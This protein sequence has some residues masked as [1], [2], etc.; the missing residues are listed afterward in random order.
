MHNYQLTITSELIFATLLSHVFTFKMFVYFSYT[1][2]RPNDYHPY[3]ARRGGR[4]RGGRQ[5]GGGRQNGGGRQSGGR[6]YPRRNTAERSAGEDETAATSAD[7]Q[8]NHRRRGQGRAKD[9]YGPGNHLHFTNTNTVNVF[10][11]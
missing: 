5:C 7:H 10:L 11:K 8:E 2:E 9:Q 1:L 3:R 4:G 6:N